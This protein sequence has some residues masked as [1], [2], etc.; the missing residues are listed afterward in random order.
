MHGYIEAYL[1]DP[2]QEVFKG[3]EELRVCS[4]I[5]GIEGDC[6]LVLKLIRGDILRGK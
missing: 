4:R 6:A 5:P 3:G 2:G 1:N